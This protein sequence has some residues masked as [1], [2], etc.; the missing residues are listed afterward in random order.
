VVVGKELEVAALSEDRSFIVDRAILEA[1]E[2]AGRNPVAA[3]HLEEVTH[4]K[5][6]AFFRTQREKAVDG[7]FH[8][9]HGHRL[10]LYSGLQDIEQRHGN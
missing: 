3:N 4:R 8:V 7:S 10:R 5:H 1:E 9:A 6:A 2:Q